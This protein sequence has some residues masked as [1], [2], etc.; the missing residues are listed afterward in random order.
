MGKSSKKSPKTGQLNAN[1]ER[2]QG[3]VNANTPPTGFA[4]TPQGASASMSASSVIKQSNDIIYGNTRLS[5]TQFLPPN[6]TFPPTT[7]NLAFSRGQTHGYMQERHSHSTH[8]PLI[9]I[10]A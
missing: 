3:T 7:G 6:V 9:E 2:L 4:I 5:G 1:Q 8:T 10:I